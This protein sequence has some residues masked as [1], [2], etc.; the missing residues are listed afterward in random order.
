[1]RNTVAQVFMHGYLELIQSNNIKDFT[2][3]I[4]NA[5]LTEIQ[6]KHLYE[7]QY[8]PQ[9]QGAIEDLNKSVQ[10]SI[11]TTYDNSKYLNLT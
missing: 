2:N 1:M 7:S 5:Y 3:K 4:L 8:H 6:V 11:S 10:R 9:F